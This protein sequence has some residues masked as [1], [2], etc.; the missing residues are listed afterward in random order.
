MDLRLLALG[1]AFSGATL[2][3]AIEEGAKHRKFALSDS[4]ILLMEHDDLAGQQWA[5]RRRQTD[6]ENIALS[7]LIDQVVEVGGFFDP[8][9][10]NTIGST[11]RRELTERSWRQ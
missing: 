9:F 3:V 11:A 8:V 2:R 4:F 10:I 7:I 5:A 6:I 1:R